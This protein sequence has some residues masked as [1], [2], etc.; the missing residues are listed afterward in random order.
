M[1]FSWL[2]FQ[3]WKVT[4]LADKVAAAIAWAS[5]PI[6]ADQCNLFHDPYACSAAHR[7]KILYNEISSAVTGVRKKICRNLYNKRMTAGLKICGP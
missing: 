3:P 5:A 1:M 7:N 2:L 6:V 4:H